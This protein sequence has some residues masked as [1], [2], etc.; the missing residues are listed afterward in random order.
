[1][2]ATIWSWITK[3]LT[4][5]ESPDSA[6]LLDQWLAA[7]PA[8]AQKYEEVRLLWELTR[9][10]RAQPPALS[11]DEFRKQSGLA[12]PEAEPEQEDQLS[13]RLTFWKY[14]VAAALTGI[15]LFAGLYAYQSD[16]ESSKT[17]TWTVRRAEEG[18]IIKISLPDSSAVWLNSGSEISFAEKF[19]DQELRSV[20]LKGEAYFEVKH[21]KHHPFVVRSGKLSTTVYGT[22]FSIRAYGNETQT[23][24]AV[25]SGKVG[26]TG[27]DEQHR[28]TTM[29]LLPNDKLS[30]T[31]E[32]GKF[33][34]TAV[35]NKDVN[36]W[37]NG[38]LIF[39]QAPLSEVFETL[40]RKYKIKINADS[41]AYAACKLTARF[42]N[43][44]LAVLLKAL[45]LSLNIQSKQIGQTIY[46]TGGNCM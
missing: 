10:L 31:P 42:D 8:N 6:A 32:T 21:D 30:Y 16:N 18:K 7:D 44:P 41:T 2:E 22:S 39:E 14:G 37:T 20:K 28:N 1:M 23:T 38:N 29:M 24:V 40:E 13:K 36:A 33:I 15:F 17:T 26:V 25:N 3:R 5:T 11:F 45:R 4:R 12:H 46:L 34:K 9:Q 43:E 27:T 35:V 19:N